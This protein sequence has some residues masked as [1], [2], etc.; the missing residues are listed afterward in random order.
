[1]DITDS[2]IVVLR[3]HIQKHFNRT[4]IRNFNYEL[5][6]CTKL[7]FVHEEPFKV[8]SVAFVAEGGCTMHPFFE[9]ENKYLKSAFSHTDTISIETSRIAPIHVETIPWS[10]LLDAPVIEC[11]PDWM[12]LSIE[13]ISYIQYPTSDDYGFALDAYILQCTDLK[14]KTVLKTTRKRT[15]LIYYKDELIAIMSGTGTYGM[16]YSVLSTDRDKFTEMMNTIITESKAED[17]KIPI[18]HTKVID[19]TKDPDV[20]FHVPGL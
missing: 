8:I 7:E 6:E 12:G 15:D 20:Y 18:E 16:R 9:F 1:M 11:E 5:S 10:R 2:L 3:N 14:L 4:E 17:Y 19:F 13:V